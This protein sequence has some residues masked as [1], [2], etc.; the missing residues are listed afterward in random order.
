MSIF[1]RLLI[2]GKYE[3]YIV[4]EVIEVDELDEGNIS[5]AAGKSDI[6]WMAELGCA[7]LG[8]KL[9]SATHVRVSHLFKL[10]LAVLP[11]TQ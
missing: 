4:E 8:L 6:L 3:C 10:P 1:S 7:T 11:I 9:S 5:A 2:G